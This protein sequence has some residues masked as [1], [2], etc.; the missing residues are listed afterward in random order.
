M[1]KRPMACMIAGSPAPLP[2]IAGT[3]FT[4]AAPTTPTMPITPNRIERARQVD[5]EGHLERAERDPGH[6]EHDGA[7]YGDAGG[8]GWTGVG[9]HASIILGLHGR[10]CRRLAPGKLAPAPGARG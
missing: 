7:P 9:R 6:G 10:S 1:M 3:A 5:G 4:T 2:S 8:G